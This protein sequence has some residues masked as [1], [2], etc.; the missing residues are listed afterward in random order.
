MVE[1]NMYQ[2]LENMQGE[3]LS[4]KSFFWQIW[5]TLGEISFALHHQKI[6]CSYTY[7]PPR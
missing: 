1:E 4:H 7:A 6:A 3:G 2:E 5:E